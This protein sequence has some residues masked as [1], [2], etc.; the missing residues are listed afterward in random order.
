MN[1]I[2][3][4]TD[5]HDM[6]RPLRICVIGAG[7]HSQFHGQALARIRSERP[8][9][10]QLAAVCDLDA[11][12]ASKYAADFGFA[13]TYSD[14]ASMLEKE[15]PDGVMVIVG[16]KLLRRVGGDVMER[17]FNALIEKPPGWSV[18][19]TAALAEIAERRGV[20][21]MVSFNRRFGPAMTRSQNWLA[22]VREKRPP[23]LI[24][25]RIVRN[26]RVEPEN[27]YSTGIHVYDTVMSLAA[28]ARVMAVTSNR[29]PERMNNAG[30]R[31]EF[32]NGAVGFC[33]MGF[34]AG[35]YEESYEVFGQNYHVRLDVEQGK[36]TIWESK[37]I[38]L[39]WH[40]PVDMPFYEKTGTLGE[41]AAFLEML[42]SG[43]AAAPDLQDGL[44]AVRAAEAA[45]DGGQKG[46]SGG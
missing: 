37:K 7:G 15:K 19:E 14:Y 2:K 26:H 38:S 8:N 18:A 13:R 34:D 9:E 29:A 22:G 6:Q 17:G 11:A 3:S 20:K 24:L 40:A 31:L 5:Q 10:L 44:R 45:R 35:N 16:P 30:V 12:R 27:M 46:I 25:G 43:S 1:T 33:V 42:R 39:E 41:T 32:D 28:P 23:E 36:L 21:N 4:T